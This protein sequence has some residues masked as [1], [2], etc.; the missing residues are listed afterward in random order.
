MHC[1]E[2]LLVMAVM[3]RTKGDVICWQ[4]FLKMT[5]GYTY[6]ADGGGV[7]HQVGLV[8]NQE[9]PSV[10]DYVRSI[11]T[12]LSNGTTDLP[13]PIGADTKVLPRHAPS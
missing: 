3:R 12:F 9:F 4:D 8:E 2:A 13:K 11:P 1:Q 6:P 7:I 10:M 5:Q